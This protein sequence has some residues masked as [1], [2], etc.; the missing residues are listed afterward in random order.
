MN[1]SSQWKVDDRGNK[2]HKSAIVADDVEFGF[3]NTIGPLSVV[4]GLGCRVTTGDQNSIGVGSVIGSPAESASGY[5]GSAHLDFEAFS[6][7]KPSPSGAVRIGSKCVI[8]DK[9]TVHAGIDGTTS[10]GDL[11]YLHSGTHLDHDVSTDIGVV[12]APAVI[13]AG[14]VSFGAFSQIGL[15][16][17]FHQG[18]AVGALAMVGMNATVKGRVEAMSLHFGTPSRLKGV[19]AV[20]LARLGLD[21]VVI[22]EVDRL[23][24]SAASGDSERESQLSEILAPLIATATEHAIRAWGA[25]N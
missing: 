8:R 1:S 4:G 6:R 2:F 16:A 22:A 7:S 17:C 19:N 18:S 10:V 20:R 12:F 25:K 9:V 21:A 11:N 23:L 24:Q 5:P 14:R 15:G 3:N 13:S